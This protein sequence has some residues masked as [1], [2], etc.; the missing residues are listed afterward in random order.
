MFTQVE[1]RYWDTSKSDNYINVQ[2]SKVSRSR[3]TAICPVHMLAK[4]DLFEGDNTLTSLGMWEYLGSP[5]YTVISGI[6][7]AAVKEIDV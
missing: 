5:Y 4:S 2:W 7:E 3:L 1:A 6:I